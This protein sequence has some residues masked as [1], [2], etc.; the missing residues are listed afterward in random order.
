[1]KKFGLTVTSLTNL[2]LIEGMQRSVDNKFR[3]LVDQ[4]RAQWEQKFSTEDPT[5]A[6]V[7]VS[8][9]PVPETPARPPVRGSAFVKS[10]K[11]TERESKIGLPNFA[12]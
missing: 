10:T 12:H 6:C 2:E 11:K 8:I 9:V 1:V 5:G 4:A 3:R 7:S